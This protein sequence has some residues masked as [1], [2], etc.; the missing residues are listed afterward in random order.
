M[1]SNTSLH[2]QR[3]CTHTLEVYV[4]VMTRSLCWLFYWSREDKGRM[5][6]QLMH[7]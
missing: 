2:T 4:G 7:K 5:S 3:P 6:H 1:T